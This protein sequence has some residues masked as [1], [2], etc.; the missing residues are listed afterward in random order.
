MARPVAATRR[1]TDWCPGDESARRFASGDASDAPLHASAHRPYSLQ[2]LLSIAVI[3]L[4][5]GSAFALSAEML[6]RYRFALTTAVLVSTSA[7]WSPYSGHVRAATTVPALP[8][9]SGAV[10]TVSTEAQLQA[11]IGQLAS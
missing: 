4:V 2:I 7:S 9:P 1:V 11:A 8:P 3:T 10:V 5:A 6:I